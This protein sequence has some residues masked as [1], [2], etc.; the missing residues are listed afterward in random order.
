MVLLGIVTLHKE[1]ELTYFTEMAKRSTDYGIQVIRFVP[2]DWESETGTITGVYYDVTKD[3]WI[4]D[5]FPFPDFIYDRCYYTNRN[6]FLENYSTMKR[7]KK[8]TTFLSTGLPNKWRVYRTLRTNETIAPYLPKTSA[9]LSSDVV[10]QR[11]HLDGKVVLKP[12]SGSQGKGILFITKKDDCIVVQTHINRQSKIIQTRSMIKFKSW[13]NRILKNQRWIAQPFLSLINEQ[14]EPFDLRILMQKNGEGHWSESGR[15]LRVGQANSL[16]SNIHNGGRVIGY[17]RWLRQL[18]LKRQNEITKQV[19]DIV[20]ALPSELEISF[21]RLFEIGIDIG[22]DKQGKCWLLEVNSKP[23]H[24]VV[25]KTNPRARKSI[26]SRPLAYCHYL[27]R[28]T[29]H[30]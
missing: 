19:A 27:L 29:V 8:K 7:L 17:E 21:G 15:G 16:I 1:Q 4:C 23:G 28:Q 22:I 12:E 3:S 25:L 18:P 20:Q 13:L 2:S 10:E 11:V 5:R 24:Q 14:N 9:V 26:Y 30:N 6:R